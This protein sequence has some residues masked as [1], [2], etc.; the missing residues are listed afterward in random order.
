VVLLAAGL[1]LAGECSGDDRCACERERLTGVLR[2]LSEHEQSAAAATTAPLWA[3]VVTETCHWAAPTDACAELHRCAR[4]HAEDRL[5]VLEPG[6][7]HAR[8]A[9]AGHRGCTPSSGLTCAN[10]AADAEDARLEATIS[11]LR[12]RHLSPDVAQGTWSRYRDAVCREDALAAG[13]DRAWETSAC[14]AVETARRTTL[15][16]ALAPRP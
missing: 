3:E 12:R 15:L 16:T 13:P 6:P 2:T 7:T 8:L 5:A 4:L 1:A 11:D 10:E 14:R 9:A